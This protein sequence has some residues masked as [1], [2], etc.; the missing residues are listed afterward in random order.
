[1]GLEQRVEDLEQDIAMLIDKQRALY[2]R[3]EGLYQV[4]KIMFAL[5]P[6][7]PAVK[8]K[9]MTTIYDATSDHMETA[10]ID[11]ETQQA[12]RASIDE[13]TRVIV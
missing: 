4:A 10:E 11:A 8:R 3:Y 9:L 5:I 1:M 6:G 7:E 13:L 2:A 12:V